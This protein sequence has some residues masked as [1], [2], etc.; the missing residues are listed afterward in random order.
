MRS[1]SEVK[2]CEEGWGEAFSGAAIKHTEVNCIWQKVFPREPKGDAEGQA[3]GVAR[4]ESRWKSAACE[5][6]KLSTGS[7]GKTKTPPSVTSEQ[8][9]KAV[10]QAHTRSRCPPLS[11]RSLHAMLPPLAAL[12]CSTSTSTAAAFAQFVCILAFNRAIP[13]R[14]RKQDQEG[15]GRELWGTGWRGWV[16]PLAKIASVKLP[17]AP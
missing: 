13:L 5:F 10:P 9:E 1:G 3:G 2:E 17:R 6:Y 12:F 14:G 11:P 15:K 4:V 7:T 8:L 16:N